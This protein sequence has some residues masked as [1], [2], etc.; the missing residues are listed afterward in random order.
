MLRTGPFRE[1]LLTRPGVSCL[2]DVTDTHRPKPH[3]M[4]PCPVPLLPCGRRS[5]SESAFCG[6]C[7]LLSMQA[8]P[9]FT[10]SRT[11]FGLNHTR[12]RFVQSACSLV[13]GAVSLRSV[14]TVL[15]CAGVS[16]LLDVTNTLRLKSHPEPPPLISLLSCGQRSESAFW[17]LSSLA[18]ETHKELFR[19]KPQPS[20]T[21]I[22]SHQTVRFHF[23][24]LVWSQ[25][26]ES[27]PSALFEYSLL[28]VC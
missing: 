27:I 16:G 7:H 22:R 1:L 6:H 26:C 13:A 24:L 12:N 14:D 20:G 28:T 4:L 9:V 10:M 5:E 25:N 17:P 11:Q 19:I 15:Y 2:H 21:I 18:R 23:L 3:P 8:F